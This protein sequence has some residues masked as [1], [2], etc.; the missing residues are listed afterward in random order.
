VERSG[1]T[2]LNFEQAR[3]N[4]IEQ[5]IRP[6]EVL[7]PRVLQVLAAVPREDFVPT[8][9]RKLAFSD[10][11]IPI[12]HGQAMMPPV[13]EGR[14]LQALSPQLADRVL[15]IGTGSGFLTACLARLAAHVDSVEIFED[16]KL[17]AAARLRT[18]DIANVKLHCGD[19]ASGWPS[20]GRYDGIV[21][22]GSVAVIP[23][24]Y[25][26]QLSLGGRLF[27]VVGSSPVMSAQLVTRIADDQWT[28]ESLFETDLPRLVN[29]ERPP[30]FQ[31]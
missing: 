14:L 26:P 5:Q 21:L 1:T 2:E 17:S 30:A 3:F 24:S 15:E 9:Y 29:A 20:A 7:D 4:M 18:H 6:W 8:R 11:S 10:L 23:S 22:T 12:G 19:G 27:A 25:L 28:T 13:L 16:L 31:L